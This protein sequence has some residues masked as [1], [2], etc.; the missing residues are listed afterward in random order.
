MNGPLRNT[1]IKR[2]FLQNI[3]IQNHFKVPI[4]NIW[5]KRLKI[6]P[7]IPRDFNLKNLHAKLHQKLWI[8]QLLH[9]YYHYYLFHFGQS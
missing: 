1:S 2:I 9:Y 7:E 8:Y 5:Q 6:Q 4:T 3:L